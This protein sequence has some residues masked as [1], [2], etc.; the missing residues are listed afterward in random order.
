[1]RISLIVAAGGSGTRFLKKAPKQTL[2]KI[3]HPF[4]GKPLLIHTLKTFQGVKE[5]KETKAAVPHGTQGEWRK[6]QK[7]FR[8]SKVGWVSGG[9]TRAESVWNALKRTDPKSDWIMV[10]DGARPLVNPAHVRE[11][12]RAV[13][14]NGSADGAILAKKVVPTIKEVSLKERTIQ[15]TVNREVL[16]EAETPQLVRRNILLKA[17]QA[18]PNAFQATDESALLE[19]VG[20]RVKAVMHEDWNPKITSFDDLKLAESYMKSKDQE[21]VR[22]GFGRDTH[23]L[24]SG[25]KLYLGGMHIPFERGAL[26]HSDGDTLLH[27]VTDAILGATGQGDIGEHFSDLDN[28]LKGIRSTKIIK[29]VVGKAREKGWAPVHVDTVIILEKP[30]LG[31][32]KKMIAQQVARLLKMKEENISIKAKTAEGLGPEGEGLAITCEAVVTMRKI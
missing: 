5:I 18:N 21:E 1:M 7:Q 23:R 25:R 16:C 15:R 32:Y 2:N 8:L 31:V 19:F 14:S 3:F 12:I 11:L 30:R 26:G 20:G 27:A 6:W 9:K 29:E 22:V 13:Q 10:H 28:R 17:Y 24:V 4:F